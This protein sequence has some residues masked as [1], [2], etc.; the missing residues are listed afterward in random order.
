[1]KNL[2]LLSLLTILTFSQSF[3]GGFIVV[4][5]SK[6]QNPDIVRPPLQ[7]APNPNLFPLEVRNN[8]IE[9]KITGQSATTSVKQ[10]FY[11][12]T[13]RQLEG[14]F[15]FPI[16][17]DAVIDNFTMLVNG[18]ETPAELL[19]AT[20]ARQIYEEIVRRAKDP[21]LLEYYN[22]S[23]F[24]VRIF[25]I[26]PRSEQRITLV[27]TETLPM[28][29]G[30]VEYS[31]PFNT[32][33]YS[34]KPL[35]QVS[36]KIDIDGLRKI[37]NVYCP[38]HEVEIN[39]H[40]ERTATVGYEARAIRSDRDFKM[41]YTI[42]DHKVGLSMLNFKEANEEGYFFLNLSPGFDNRTEVIQ[43]D[44][45]FVLDASG[46]MAGE[47]M[48]QAKKALNF[49]I[50]NLNSKDRFN[51]IR[52]STEASS[53]YGDLQEASSNNI[54]RARSY[55]KELR[56]I[57]GTNIEEA[58]DLALSNGGSDSRPYFVIFLTDGKPTIGETQEDPLLAKI[59]ARNTG[60]TR[61]FTF[62]IGTELNT[63]L[64]DKL[65]EMTQAYRTYVLPTEDIEIKV[66]NFYEK[67][68]SPILTDIE[69]KF[70]NSISVSS[71]YPNA[72]PDLFSGSS[73]S[74]MGRYSGFGNSE[75]TLTGYVNGRKESFAYPVN[76]ERRN[77]ENNFIPSLWATRCVGHLLDQIRLH[78]ENQELVAEVVRLA[79]KH[80]IV[81]P[82]TSYLIIE[83]ERQLVNRGQI[84][85][86]DQLLRN[87]VESAPMVQQALEEDLADMKEK[88]DGE[89]SVRASQ[90]IQTLNKAANIA[91]TRTDNSRLNFRDASGTTKNLAGG[92]QNIRGRAFY[93][94]NNI[95][96]DAN[97][98]SNANQ[99]T[100]RIKF[101]SAE[102]FKLMNDNPEVVEYLALGQNVRFVLNNEIV[103]VY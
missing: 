90:E 77:S 52:F 46:S 81:T 18:V 5:P 20:K 78:G 57:G 26:L 6:H 93:N 37:K 86:T 80:G 41:Y 36:F 98:Q 70:A 92:I 87:R 73:L 72:L 62:G 23:L 60:Q 43:K 66:S 22:K 102:Y 95:W 42:D 31:F 54:S 51:I 16:P 10:V 34:A 3:A 53:L 48:D 71:V 39:R 4:D 100:N 99:R 49:C 88:K 25:P 24:R 69:L 79:K 47:K 40:S 7:G 91:Q 2:I 96:V 67:V 11:N 103:E 50:E 85:P 89:A 83:D 21:A 63:H 8:Q 27:Y 29:D 65:T 59:K 76:F 12:P 75:V 14:H 74:I 58:L 19:D 32:E 64:L 38:T 28:E 9:S 82:Y 13:N 30:T 45:T 1:M 94:N 84:R 55:I 35:N 101:N 61:I 33:K 56:A 97:V 44:V 68:S 17:K 15:L